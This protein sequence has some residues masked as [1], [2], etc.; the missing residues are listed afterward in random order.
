LA[1]LTDLFPCSRPVFFENDDIN[2]PYSFRGSSFVIFYKDE[3]YLFTLRHVLDVYESNQ[4]SVLVNDT[5]DEFIPFNLFSHPTYPDPTESDCG[6][7]CVF[8]I[9]KDLLTIP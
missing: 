6:D 7:V 9:A 5:H 2:F 1:T 4:V 3:Y 8:R